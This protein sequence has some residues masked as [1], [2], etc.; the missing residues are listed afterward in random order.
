MSKKK[1]IPEKE[2][3]ID[4]YE[5][6]NEFIEKLGVRKLSAKNIEIMAKYYQKLFKK[7]ND[8][9][10]CNVRTIGQNKRLKRLVKGVSISTLALG[11]ILG[12]KNPELL[13]KLWGKVTGNPRVEIGEMYNSESGKTNF[14]IINEKN[15]KNKEDATLNVTLFG[16]DGEKIEKTV[17]D[18]TVISQGY[19]YTNKLD[20]LLENQYIVPAGRQAKVRTSLMKSEDNVARI[21]EEGDAFFGTLPIYSS[22]GNGS[23]GIASEVFIPG[24]EGNQRFYVF[25]DEAGII[26]PSENEKDVETTN[27][28]VKRDTDIYTSP[29]SGIV[30][31][32]A[33]KGAS[34]RVTKDSKEDPIGDTWFKSGWFEVTDENGNTIGFIHERDIE[35]ENELEGKNTIADKILSNTRFNEDRNCITI[36]SRDME[37]DQLSYLIDNYEVPS[38]M[39]VVVDYENAI[40]EEYNTSRLA[41]CNISHVFIRAGASKSTTGEIES[42]CTDFVGLAEVC[43]NKNIP[44]SLY[45]YSTSVSIEEADKEL[46]KIREGLQAIKEMGI[47]PPVNFFVDSELASGDELDRQAGHDVTNTK[48]YMIKAIQDTIQ[49]IFGPEL[50][51]KVG[52]Y[53]TWREVNPDSSERILDLGAFTYEFGEDFPLWTTNLIDSEGNLINEEVI[54]YF[55]KHG[56]IFSYQTVHNVDMDGTYYDFGE[57]PEEAFR[58]IL[59]NYGKELDKNEEEEEEEEKSFGKQI[60]ESA[61]SILGTTYSWKEPEVTDKVLPEVVQDD[62]T[63]KEDVR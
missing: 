1:E 4:L 63:T 36:D 35:I 30:N 61:N 25:L 15:E 43:S 33:L 45:F 9:K 34:L 28:V 50:D 24:V 27:V 49:D 56:E 12:T 13:K 18:G 32:H 14:C 3:E 7:Y 47:E 23:Q 59:E 57:I 48:I 22:A 17:S 31:A 29:E 39:D 38:T 5:G 42:K 21:I 51:C 40:K 52:L 16:I 37:A 20:R 55:N 60:I 46:E 19:V 2:E 54:E 8:L 41:G 44:Y 6:M 58:K 10:D 11:V 53:T 26:T 62:W